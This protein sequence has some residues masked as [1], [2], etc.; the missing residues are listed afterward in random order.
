MHGVQSIQRR[1]VGWQMQLRDASSTARRKNQH[2]NFHSHF[3][4]NKA[5]VRRET[6]VANDVG[7]CCV[8]ERTRRQRTEV[9]NWRLFGKLVKPD[10]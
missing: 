2:S 6:A 9:F 4:L 5:D 1:A 3:C 10:V 8:V 7:V